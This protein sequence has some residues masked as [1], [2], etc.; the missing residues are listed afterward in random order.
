[1]DKDTKR[2]W[3]NRGRQ[4]VKMFERFAPLTRAAHPLA[5]ASV[6]IATVS[7]LL[8]ANS[9]ADS[10]PVCWDVEEAALA[11][12]CATADSAGLGVIVD[13][14]HPAHFVRSLD[15]C[16]WGYTPYWRHGP[17]GDPTVLPRAIWEALGTAI[18]VTHLQYP[19]SFTSMQRDRLKCLP[20]SSVAQRIGAELSA[21]RD[22]GERSGAVLYGPPGTGKS[23]IARAVAQ[24]LGGFSMR[25]CLGDVP[26]ATL[27]GLVDIMAPRTVILDDIDRGET[28]HVLDLAEILTASGIAVIATVNDMSAIDSA[29]LR[30]GRLGLHYKIEG[31]ASDLV[32]AILDGIAV[33]LDAR[34]LCLQAT[35]AIVRDYAG[36]VRA[37]GHARAMEILKERVQ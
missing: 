36:H 26:P 13:E 30:A 22:A 12:V 35:A 14:P 20:A 6:G 33:P 15:G 21:L 16:E 9:K 2:Q 34:A 18:E 1:M 3:A 5:W 28:D 37:L 25:A 23:Q 32:D 4:A 8:G 29:L 7:D 11:A 19:R 17:H 27:A 24:A 31:I 10:E